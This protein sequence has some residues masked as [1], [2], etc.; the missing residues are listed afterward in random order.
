MDDEPVAAAVP[1]CERYMGFWCQKQTRE[2]LE[3]P[4]GYTLSLA[5]ASASASGARRTSMFVAASS[6]ARLSWTRT[7]SPGRAPCSD[8]FTARREDTD[9]PEQ[10]GADVQGEV[11]ER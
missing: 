8:I 9:S 3:P 6:Q 11:P 10:G 1:R 2:D 7:R 4:I 5:G